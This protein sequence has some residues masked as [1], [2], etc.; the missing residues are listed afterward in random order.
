MNTNTASVQIN[1]L[2]TALVKI[3][4]DYT[5]D[6]CRAVDICARKSMKELVEETKR[7]APYNSHSSKKHYRE[8]ISSRREKM[9]TYRTAYTWYVKAPKYRLAHLLNNGHVV[10]NGGRIV[11]RYKGDQHITKNADSVIAN[12]KRQVKEAVGNAGH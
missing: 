1:E 11:G 9:G 2:D 6:V 12:Y 7:D 10:R 5:D 3:L 4:T 8:L